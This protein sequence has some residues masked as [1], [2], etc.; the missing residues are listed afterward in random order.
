MRGS[1]IDVATP[2]LVVDADVLDAN[3]ERGRRDFTRSGV[4]YR[5]HAKAHKSA[6]IARKQI[7]HGA[8]G[9]CCAK[10]GEAEALAAE[11]I[12]DILITTPVIGGPK[13]RRLVELQRVARVAVVV[14]D[15]ENANQIASFSS[16]SGVEVDLLVELDVGQNRCGV[17]SPD[18]ALQLARMIVG[19]AGVRFRGLQ[20]YQGKSQLVP[21]FGERY[22]QATATAEALRATLDRLSQAEIVPE[23]L[24]GGG[25]GTSA[26]DIEVG[27]LK[28]LQPGSYIFMDTAYA[29]I[30]WDADGRPPPFRQSLFVVTTVI[31]RPSGTCV[32]VDAGLKA[33]S[34]DSG[35]PSVKD[36]D[37]ARFSFAGDE[38]GIIECDAGA[39]PAIGAQLVLV[40][41]HCDTTV[42]LYDEFVIM[43]AGVVEGAWPIDARGKLQ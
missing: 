1:R 28:E 8:V 33:L 35:N 16:S 27:C 15:I 10:L 6:R 17:R 3:L 4:H 37:A 5:P 21:R 32:I 7:E 12:S 39:A 2:A 42:N 18:A 26:V 29:G 25:T 19:S 20:G 41:S 24:T 31:S 43:R 9:I 36:D 11:G 34:S 14:D 38:H 22:A 40:P 13:I 23:I 30:E